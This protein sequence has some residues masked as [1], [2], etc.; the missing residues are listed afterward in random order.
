MISAPPP[1]FT[2]DFQSS[3]RIPPSFTVQSRLYNEAGFIP[4]PLQFFGQVGGVYGHRSVPVAGATDTAPGGV[5]WA[6]AGTHM[7]T[8]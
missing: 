7:F 4:H 1:N 5:A 3:K 8:G 6:A 2:F